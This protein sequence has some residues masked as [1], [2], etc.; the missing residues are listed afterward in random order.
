MKRF[1]D[2]VKEEA[3]LYATELGVTIPHTATTVKPAGCASLDTTVKTAEGVMTMRELFARHGY[4]EEYL[5][6]MPD[7]TWLEPSCQ[8]SVLDMN[9]DEK[10]VTKLYVNGVKEVFEITFEDGTVAKLTG[11]H[12][13]MTSGGWKRVDELTEDD[14]IVSL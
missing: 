13:L 6:K 7:A 10:D 11:N 14:E 12:R 3:V 5:K 2:A 1:S 4:N 8:M 9:G